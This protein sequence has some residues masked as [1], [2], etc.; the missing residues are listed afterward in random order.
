MKCFFDMNITEF[1][2]NER[3]WKI[4]T[5]NELYTDLINNNTFIHVS[6]ANYCNRW[7]LTWLWW[8]WMYMKCPVRGMCLT[9]EPIVSRLTMNNSQAIESS[10]LVYGIKAKGLKSNE[11]I[12][13]KKTF[14]MFMHDWIRSFMRWSVFK[15][16]ATRDWFML[17]INIGPVSRTS[18]KNTWNIFF[19]T[20]LAIC[21]RQTQTTTQNVDILFN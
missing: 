20:P 6:H 2:N 9:S 8:K 3:T 7:L 4:H 15:Q 13:K 14:E 1:H 12:L 19:S 17:I 18:C 16:V 5:I 10:S 21:S 11:A